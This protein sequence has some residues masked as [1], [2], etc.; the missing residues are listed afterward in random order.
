MQ[1]I[2]QEN[3]VQAVRI[4][5]LEKQAAELAA[6]KTQVATMAKVIERL[7]KDRMVAAAR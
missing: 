1:T 6:L 4:A 5:S 2:R 7:D 3:E